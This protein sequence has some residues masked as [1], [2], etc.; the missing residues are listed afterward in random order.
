MSKHDEDVIR[1]IRAILQRGNN[2]EIKS[3]KDGNIK[4]YEVKKHIVAV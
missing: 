4:V 1:K 2:V 3:T